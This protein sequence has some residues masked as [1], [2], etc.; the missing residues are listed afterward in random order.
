MRKIVLFIAAALL[1]IAVGLPS[2][3][4]QTYGGGNP[5]YRPQPQNRRP[6]NPMPGD[7]RSFVGQLSEE[8]VRHA[9]NLAEA[10]FQYYQGWN[11][12]IT[13]RE[14]AVLFKTEE[15]AAAARLFSRLALD[16]GDYFRRD[17]LRTNLFTASRYLALSFRQLEEQMRLGG[18]MNDF[19]R[20]RRDGRP[21]QWQP[22]RGITGP[23]GL[24]EMRR[25]LDRIELEFTNWR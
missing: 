21:F 23:W 24:A 8:L 2:G 5:Q 13:D 22:Q 7:R 19:S 9:E 18:I 12:S 14:Q 25:I 10:G 20:A 11:G 15:F 6:D 3:A 1:I 17:G 4:Q 16:R